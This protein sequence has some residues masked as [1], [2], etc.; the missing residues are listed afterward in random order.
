MSA[1]CIGSSQGCCGSH[2]LP[3]FYTHTLVA[4]ASPLH[5]IPLCPLAAPLTLLSSPL[6]LPKACE[7]NG[8][9]SFDCCL[10]VPCNWTEVFQGASRKRYC[11]LLSALLYPSV[12]ILPPPLCFSQRRVSRV[13]GSS[14]DRSYLRSLHDWTEVRLECVCFSAEKQQSVGKFWAPHNHQNDPCTS[15]RI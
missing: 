6:S 15:E 8:Y 14:F 10:E 9:S 7:P 1:P 5:A 13:A 2:D 11:P 3:L 4:D 12:L